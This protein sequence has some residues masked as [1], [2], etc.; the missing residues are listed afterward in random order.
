MDITTGFTALV[1]FVIKV[2]VWL[3]LLAPMVGLLI[4]HAL[5]VVPDF[6]PFNQIIFVH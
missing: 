1:I 5:N 4:A 3:A 6:W 2:M